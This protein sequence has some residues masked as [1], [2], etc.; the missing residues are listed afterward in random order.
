MHATSTPVSMPRSATTRR[1]PRSYLFTRASFSSKDAPFAHS[2][3]AVT[4]LAQVAGGAEA[5]A[6]SANIIDHQLLD[7]AHDTWTRSILCA[8]PL[9]FSSKDAHGG[10]QERAGRRWRWL[11]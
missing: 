1:A 7:V 10:G 3:A 11:R 5:R 9:S 4:A 2:R 6:W 8:G